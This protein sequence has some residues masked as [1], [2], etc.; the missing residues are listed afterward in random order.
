[1][2]RGRFYTEEEEKRLVK[3]MEVFPDMNY[4]ELAEF[5]LEVGSIKDR[6]VSGV[7]QHI[8]FLKEPKE[9]PNEQLE[10]SM[11]EYSEETEM[12]NTIRNERDEYKGKYESLLDAIIGKASLYDNI[13]GTHALKLDWR[14]IFTWLLRYEAKRY[15]SKIE[16]LEMEMEVE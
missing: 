12:L 1:M 16:E 15:Y 14:S 8:R 7:A 9:N 11:S 10:L 4:T 3:L 5:S 2:S 6:S 13:P